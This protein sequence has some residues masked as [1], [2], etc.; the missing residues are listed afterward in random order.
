ML[1]AHFSVFL[2]SSV[3]RGHE[4]GGSEFSEVSEIF[5]KELFLVS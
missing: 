5:S 1:A 2:D 3:P 4:C